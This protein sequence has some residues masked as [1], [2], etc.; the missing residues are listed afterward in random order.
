MAKISYS[1]RGGDGLG[2]FYIDNEDGSI[3]TLVPLD[4]EGKQHYWLAVYAQDH[5]AAPLFSRLDVYVEV[6]N[7]NDNVP[8]TSRPVYYPKI[9]ENSKP[10]TPVIT[11]HAYDADILEDDQVQ[12]FSY[13]IISG[14]PQ[15]L[16]FINSHV[17]I[18]STT[19]RILDREAQS[20]HTLEILVSDK[21]N[22]PL[23]STTRVIISVEDENDNRPKF[24]ERFYKLSVPETVVE[25]E[26]FL[27]K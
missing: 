2:T 1:I 9:A 19:N 20:E 3:K 15:S 5:G 7:E 4:R 8:L 25:E 18:I 14:N 13:D 23:N 24:L 11:L 17:G 21:G 22:P 12:E 10:F 16:F 27:Q 6:L 26:K